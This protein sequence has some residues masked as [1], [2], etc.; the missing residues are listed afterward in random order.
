VTLLLTFLQ[1]TA[2]RHCSSSESQNPLSS[3]PSPLER[4]K[5]LLAS[6]GSLSETSLLLEAAIQQSDFGE[7]GYEAWILLGETLSMDEKEEAAIRALQTG[8]EIAQRNGVG[9]GSRAGMISLAIAYTNES[10]EKAS[11]TM[12]GRWLDDRFPGSLKGSDELLGIKDANGSSLGWSGRTMSTWAIKEKVTDAYLAAARM[13]H[14]EGIADPDVQIG[15][16]VL[17]YTGGD[18]VRAADCFQSALQARPHV[19]SLSL[20]SF[21]L[22]V[23]FG[24]SLL[25]LI[26]KLPRITLFGIATDLA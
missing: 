22:P 10:Y 18:Y 19:S 17:L 2:E 3:T 8:V 15:L 16:G 13:Q 21:R 14:A 9:E 4:A 7:G 26:A 23:L 12:L 5:E 20:F 24:M 1:A 6:N 25:I 11:Y